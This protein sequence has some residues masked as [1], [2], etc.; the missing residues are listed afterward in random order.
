MLNKASDIYLS[1]SL[2]CIENSVKNRLAFNRR[3]GWIFNNVYVQ[4]CLAAGIDP[5]SFRFQ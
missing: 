5:E 1:Y 3:F 2:K 4:K